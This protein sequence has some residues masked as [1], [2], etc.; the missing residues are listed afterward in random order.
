MEIINR[1]AAVI[2]PKKIFTDML[3][4]I[5]AIPTS[6]CNMRKDCNVILIPDFDTQDD[7]VDYIRNNYQKLLR[8]ELRDWLEEKDINELLANVSY[9][10][11]RMWFDIEVHQTVRDAME[12][13]LVDEP[14]EQ[15]VEDSVVDMHEEAL[16]EQMEKPDAPEANGDDLLYFDLTVPNPECDYHENLDNPKV[17]LFA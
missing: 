10:I 13:N 15:P 14:A 5:K 6:F 7:A 9:S 4:S 17:N 16:P 12:G 11:F 3:R 2:K 8:T 1:S